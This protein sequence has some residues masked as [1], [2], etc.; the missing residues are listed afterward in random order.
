[1]E[2]RKK[3]GNYSERNI[4]T[5]FVFLFLIISQTGFTQ[6]RIRFAETRS[7]YKSVS[8]IISKLQKS[9]SNSLPDELNKLWTKIKNEGLP[10]K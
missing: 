6:D 8:P 4:Y 9:D 2:N 10:Q 7:P 3:I 5:F 1:M